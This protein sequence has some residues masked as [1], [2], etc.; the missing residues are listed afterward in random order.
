MQNQRGASARP[1][2]RL[3]RRSAAGAGIAALEAEQHLRQAD[4][5]G[6][7]VLLVEEGHVPLALATS[8]PVVQLA[9]ACA[10]CVGALPLRVQIA[11][12]LRQWQPAYVLVEVA[13][14]EHAA[15]L[16]ETLRR[17]PLG[18]AVEVVDFDA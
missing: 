18:T 4:P 7:V 3:L 8:S 2:L 6:Q 1:I 10:C 13:A 9:P 14:L 12:A 17:G 15:R 16:A 5:S 11:R